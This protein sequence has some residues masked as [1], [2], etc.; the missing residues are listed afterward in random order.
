MFS[1]A[2]KFFLDIVTRHFFSLPQEF[3]SWYKNFLLA[4]RKTSFCKEKKKNLAV[5][6][7]TD[8]LLYQEKKIH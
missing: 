7:K 8:L 1:Y 6:T 3:L 2:K 4:V 5:R